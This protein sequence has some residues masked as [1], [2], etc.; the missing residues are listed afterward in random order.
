MFEDRSI[1]WMMAGG[2]RAERASERFDRVHAQ[3]PREA[4]RDDRRAAPVR[5]AIEPV[6]LRAMAALGLASAGVDAPSTTLDC[7]AA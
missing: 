2:N 7:C 1:A 5:G 3:A 6:R 4:R